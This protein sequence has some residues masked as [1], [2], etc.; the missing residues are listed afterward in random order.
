MA[1]SSLTIFESLVKELR[2]DSEGNGFVSQRG[3]ARMCGIKSIG[4]WGKGDL[5][6]TREID[7]YLSGGGIEVS[8]I[9]TSNGIP[10]IVAAEVIG[11]YAEEKQNPTA[12]QYSR[13]F[14][15]YGLR[16]VIQDVTGFKPPIKPRLTNEQIIE[17]CC[18]PVPTEWQ[19]RFPQDYYDNL[20]RLTEL[21]PFGNSRPALWAQLTKE[22][23]YDY[24]PAGI[25][26]EI[27]NCKEETG[28]YEKLHQFL[29]EDGVMILEQHQR[30]LL[31]LMQASSSLQQLKTL[32]TQ[33]CTGNYQL[34][35]FEA[36]VK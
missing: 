34:V 26:D 21:K 3:L 33:S 6:L 22:L 4:S 10:D 35:L 13:A 17:L 24:L 16:K 31:T 2:C 28:G 27:K 14:R 36:K 30:T 20:S 19:R 32:L 9:D 25:Y 15:A 12:K 8:A 5:F 7:E 1:T 18:L 23:V 29:S 11:F